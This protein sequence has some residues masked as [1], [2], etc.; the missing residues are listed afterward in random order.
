MFEFGGVR[1]QKLAETG[2][3]K[4]KRAS[5]AGVVMLMK[6]MAF[7]SDYANGTTVYS[8]HAYKALP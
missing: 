4:L 5:K 3:A 7:D 8:S 2:P 1:A 6:T